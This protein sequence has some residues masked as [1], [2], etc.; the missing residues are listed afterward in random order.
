MNILL[1]YPYPLYDRSKSHED[2][3]S[4]VPIGA[5]YVAAVLKE[6]DYNVHVLNWFNIHKTP[7][8]VV[9]ILREK[10]PDVIGFS[11]LN[12]NRWGG[13]EIARIAKQLN[14]Q[15]KIVFGG[16]GASFLWKHFLDNFHE[17]DFVVIGEAE[18]TFLALVKTI[19]RK[20]SANLKN[21]KGIAF[22]NSKGIHKTGGAAFIDNLD[23]I[24]IPAKHFTYNHVI[25]S[26]G[27]PGKCTFCGSP[28]FWGRRLRFR[29]P[30]NFV[31]ELELLCS[32]GV[33]FFFFSDDTFTANKKRVVEIC[34]KIIE[35]DLD[36]TWFAI[37]RV[38][39]I[40]EDILCWMRK[41]GCTQISYGIE[42]GS[43]KIRKKLGKPLDTET[44]KRAFSL[45][46]RY[47]ILARAY[48]IYGSPGE[49]WETI[50]ETLN[51]IKEVKPFICISYILEIYPGTK[52]YSDFLK[53]SN[54]TDDIW[55][56]KIEGICYFESD[57]I[58]TK[59]N[60][61]AFGKR[62]R[63]EHYGN[64]GSFAESLELI[65]KNEFYV[66]HA[67]F[68][69]RLAMTFS[70]GD[71]SKIEAIKE[72]TALAE[73]L[74]RKALSYAPNERAYLGLGHIKQREQRFQQSADILY[75]GVKHFPKSEDLNICLAISYMNR[76]KFDEALNYLL[77]F[78]DSHQAIRHIA[79]CYKELG[80]DD[81]E[82][83]F[84]EKAHRFQKT[85]SSARRS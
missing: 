84:S 9:E 63:E 66:M 57:S 13:I 67:D 68:C 80:S 39:C 43:E 48:L 64:L 30:E 61:L 71:Y 6:H 60:V 36:I 28:K 34:K 16:V 81:K 5:Y 29:S 22:R 11:I 59:D 35:K 79:T 27:C 10:K 21:I 65:E 12:A 45:T 85:C 54:A 2:D 46:Y 14:P 40:D 49:T 47:G 8:R 44:I 53:N 32:K 4:I 83:E 55:L 52:L 70:H 73:A 69:S 17:I 42:S 23:D 78:Q 25:S 24:P 41:A 37:S 74:F 7:K 33:N 1:I 20:G 3:I 77:M 26:R 50:E 51:L 75:E 18:H 19:E 62:L 82:L 38:D 31:H 72:K 58:L 56:K 76:R 15:V